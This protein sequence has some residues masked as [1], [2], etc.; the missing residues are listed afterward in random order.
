MRYTSLL[1]YF[2][3]VIDRNTPTEKSSI[4]PSFR[5]RQS[6]GGE[7]RVSTSYVLPAKSL[8]NVSL[9]KNKC[10]AFHSNYLTLLFLMPTTQC[11]FSFR[12]VC[13]LFLL[14]LFLNKYIFHTLNVPEFLSWQSNVSQEVFWHSTLALYCLTSL[15]KVCTMNKQLLLF[16]LQYMSKQMAISDFVLTEW[17]FYVVS[18]F[19]LSILAFW[20]E[21][22]QDQILALLFSNPF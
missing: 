18:C 11:Y 9:Y 2:L 5:Q 10:W 22:P 12:S 8:C 16:S 1:F 13:L 14:L 20:N 7:V 3:L 21:K 19:P 6:L 15:S 4:F 17:H